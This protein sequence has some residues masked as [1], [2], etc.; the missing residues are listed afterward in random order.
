MKAQ[1]EVHKAMLADSDDEPAQV[2]PLQDIT[3]LKFR[4]WG[5]GQLPLLRYDQ[6]STSRITKS[7]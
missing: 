6:G 2:A 7:P 5:C 3:V 4:V 1:I